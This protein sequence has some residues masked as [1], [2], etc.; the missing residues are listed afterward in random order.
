MFVGRAHGEVQR[1]RLQLD[2]R[3]LDG[4]DQRAGDTASSE[5]LSNFDVLKFPRT[6]VREVG[7]AHGLVLD[8]ATK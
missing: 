7:V 6:R 1:T 8:P 2:R 5:L 3:S 4:A